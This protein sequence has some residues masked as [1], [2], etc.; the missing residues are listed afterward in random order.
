MQHRNRLLVITHAIAMPIFADEIAAAISPGDVEAGWDLVEIVPDRISIADFHKINWTDLEAKQEQQIIERLLPAITNRRR[1]AYFGF[2]P[3]P[4]AIHLGRRLYG[5]KVDVYQRNHKTHEWAWSTKE[6]TSPTGIMKPL[7]VPE[8]G[9]SEAGDLVLRV[10]IT[11]RISAKSTQ[12]VVSSPLA[13]MDVMVQ[14]TSDDV[15]TNKTAFDEALTSIQEALR[16]LHRLFPKARAVHLFFAGPLSL[17]FQIGATLNPTIFPKV[18]TYQYHAASTPQYIPAIVLGGQTDTEQWLHSAQNATEARSPATKPVKWAGKELV[19]GRQP[20]FLDIAFLE[21]GLN[22]ARSI[23]HIKV[24]NEAF[25]LFYGTGFLI[26]PNTILTNHH[27]LF[28]AGKPV[29]KALIWFNYERD[30]QGRDRKVESCEADISTIIGD[31]EHDWAIIRLVK[32]P[33]EKY[34][35]LVLGA[36]KPVLEGDFVYIVQHPNGEPKKIGMTHNQ[37]VAVTNDCVQY[38]TDTLPGSSGAPVF[39]DAWHVIALHREGLE[40]RPDEKHPFKNQGTH[41]D[42]VMEG[43]KAANIWGSE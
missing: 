37:V 26:A 3:L 4:P 8:Q 16:Q 1:I 30:V 36:N 19:T 40:G 7:D 38:L 6:I 39:N 10:S 31:P 43:L 24:W 42:R 27:V 2:G 34:D 11:H 22:V 14:K 21:K 13:E 41:I 18:V 25:E 33:R 23:V 9:S 15:L 12:E 29:Q 5:Y 20:S 32:P 35:P 28:D 17:A